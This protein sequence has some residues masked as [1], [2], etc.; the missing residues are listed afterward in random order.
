[1]TS[2]LLHAQQADRRDRKAPELVV[3]SGGRM[4]TCDALVFTPDGRYL[5]AT[6]DDKVVRV[7]PFH[8]GRLDARSARVL[9]WPAWREERGAIYALAVSPDPQARRVVVGGP[10][11]RAGNASAALLDR[12]T[13]EVLQLGMP[14]SG[15]NFYA[16]RA[17]AF[18]PS[19]KQVAYGT[20]DGS[21][22][23][24]DLEGRR[25]SRVGRHDPFKGE[26]L[27]RI[28]LVRFLANKQLLTLSASGVLYEWDLTGEPARK[29]ERR[30]LDKPKWRLYRAAL[31]LD[32][33]WLAAA[34][35]GPIVHVRSLDGEQQN[36]IL[37]R[38]RE[39]PR[40]IAFAPDG[41][42]AVGVGSLVPK[43]SFY[44][45]SNDRIVLYDLARK[46]ARASAGPRHTYRA[47]YLAFHPKQSDILAVAGGDNHEVV[48][49]DLRDTRRP[50]S[51]IRGKG[52]GLWDV[53]LS[54]SGRYLGIRDQRDPTSIDPNARARGPW[55]VFDLEQRD[56][57]GADRFKPLPR[58]KTLSGWK[59]VPDSRD[60]LVWYA[61]DPDGR[62]HPLPRTESD[63]M[64]RCYAFLPPVPGQPVRLA[65]GH[66]WG[67]SVYTLSPRRGARRI[68]LCVGHQ[69]EV[70]A[71]GTSADG[72]WLVSA[73][74]DQTVAAW[75]LTDRPSGS[76]PGAAFRLAPGRL[77]VKSVDLFSPA[78]EAGLVSGDEVVLL[79]VDASKVFDRLTPPEARRLERLLGMAERAL[80]QE[81]GQPRACLEHILE[82]VPGHELFVAVRRG[83][84]RRLVPMLTRLK[85]RPLWRFFPAGEEWVLWMAGHSF[86]DTSTNGDFFIGWHMNSGEG[87]D[88]TPAFH[89]AERFRDL[90]HR[91]T[92]IDQLLGSRDPAKALKQ[93]E[94]D[95]RPADFR[96]IEPAL[97]KIEPTAREVHDRDLEVTVLAD[98]SSDNPDRV[99]DR[100]EL[101]VNDHRIRVWR[102]ETKRFRAT[103]RI[104]LTALRSGKN[105]LTIQCY[106]RL[107]GRGEAQ[108]VVDC[109]RK[110]AQQTLHG[111]A[112]GI[113]DYHS[114]R[115]PS[116]KPYPNLHG[117]WNDAREMVRVWKKRSAPLYAAAHLDLLPDKDGDASPKKV[118][119][120]LG[121]IAQR[122]RPD[123]VFLL[124]FAGHGE[125]VQSTAGPT[126]VFCGAS[127]DHKQPDKTGL[128]SRDLYAALAA[129]PCRKVVLLDACRAGDLPVSPV[130]DLTPGGQGP[131]ILGACRRGQHSYENPRLGE[132][133]GGH[134]LFSY[135]VLAALDKE[136]PRADKNRDG[137]LSPRELFE[138]VETRLP[139]LL[140]EYE[141]GLRHRQNPSHFP[142]D[143]ETVP[144]LARAKKVLNGK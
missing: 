125:V 144:R 49:W 112:V 38:E 41:R 127:F 30:L 67:L 60:R 3:E 90:F 77:F 104:P 102:P 5:L 1:M 18:A 134:G 80:G 129:I 51:V 92:V 96:K 64:P 98:P 32:Q 14:P 70:T 12:L 39:F 6:G 119:E 108:A 69:C 55:R 116:G 78:W 7:W 4:G 126:F 28:V 128:S 100:T 81:T 59:V 82:A 76:E 19:G 83:K 63:E 111:L 138:Y 135:A 110:P 57:V 122:A 99:P 31:S 21:I 8:Q 11:L 37:L 50:V 124:F 62:K 26:K 97:V 48:C 68:R 107:A 103:V 131:I 52:S 89:P 2:P 79:A 139:L 106:N 56:W 101:W 94:K 117:T 23:L 36:D 132:T 123:D 58:L 113:R 120:K 93:S 16:I 40:S 91:R 115:G 61:V 137:F 136:F 86:Y 44:L 142:A 53:A 46:P 66:Y 88:K 141:P 35:D 10:G 45:E 34:A 54:A 42:L 130:R 133:A 13:G 109:R 65:V 71:L 75:D 15:G 29:K 43:A 27:N 25:T 74:S 143:L 118:L 121:E 73:S 95:A 47:E 22:W 140:E 17:A 85:H 20:S 9:R 84:S 87:L 33:K 24:W 114:S 72:R 105:V